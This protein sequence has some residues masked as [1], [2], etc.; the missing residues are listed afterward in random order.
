MRTQYEDSKVTTKLMTSS[1]TTWFFTDA[2]PTRQ[3]IRSP[4]ETEN[5]V[6]NPVECPDYYRKIDREIVI[7]T[8]L[9][10]NINI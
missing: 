4:D 10:Q 2:T 7:Q 9:V 1:A 3:I 6:L 8:D 5:N